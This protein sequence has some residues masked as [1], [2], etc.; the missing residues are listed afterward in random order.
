[1]NQISFEQSQFAGPRTSVQLRKWLD[2][3]LDEV[4]TVVIDV[5]PALAHELLE[6]NHDNRPFRPRGAV[7]SIECYAAAMQRSEWRVNG[8]GIIVSRDGQLNDGQNRLKAVIQSKLPS[9]KMQITFGV[10]RESRVTVD[11]GAARTPGDILFLRGEKN[12]NVLAHALQFLFAYY[13]KQTF[14]ARPSSHQLGLLLDAHPDIRAA[15]NPASLLRSLRGSV[16]YLAGALYLC[17]QVDA[18]QA[19]EFL[20]QVAEGLF[21][22]ASEP[23]YLLHKRLQAHA[24]NPR[25]KLHAVEQAALFIKAFNAHK[26]RQKL[27]GLRWRR[28]GDAAEAFPAPKA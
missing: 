1:M 13:G 21:T 9:V 15:V 16:G 24:I 2:Q 18:V 12:A 27:S 17:R 10:E 22:N 19:D 3:G 14:T 26:R 23:A 20:K 4:F 6:R 25:E 28:Y 7:R 5:T 8:Q 11:Q